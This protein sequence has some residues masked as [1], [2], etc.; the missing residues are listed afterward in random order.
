MQNNNLVDACMGPVTV[1]NGLQANDGN[2]AMDMG[3]DV[4][5]Q[6]MIM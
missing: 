3:E 2:V 4:V 5:M 1:P 6:T